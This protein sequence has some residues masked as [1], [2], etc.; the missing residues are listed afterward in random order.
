MIAATFTVCT[1]CAS[2]GNELNRRR[3]SSLILRFCASSSR[4]CRIS[5]LPFKT[6]SGRRSSTWDGNLK[7]RFELSIPG[8]RNNA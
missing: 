7:L 2:C 6:A 3:I 4:A 1:A 8:G 5:E